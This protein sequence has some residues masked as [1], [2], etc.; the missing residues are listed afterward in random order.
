[1]VKFNGSSQLFVVGAALGEVEVS[2]FM[3]GAALREFLNASRRATCKKMLVMR[4][5]INLGCE[6][7]CGLFH[8]RIILGLSP[9]WK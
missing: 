3:A 4:S 6:A 9:H 8:S 5:K 2:L 7:V 1:L